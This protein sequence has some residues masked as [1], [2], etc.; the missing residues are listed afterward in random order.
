MCVSHTHTHTHLTNWVLRWTTKSGNQRKTK[1]SP[2]ARGVVVDGVHIPSRQNTHPDVP[3]F[4]LFMREKAPKRQ[5]ARTARQEQ[6]SG[7]NHNSLKFNLSKVDSGIKRSSRA[8]QSL[9]YAHTHTHSGSEAYTH[10]HRFLSR[11]PLFK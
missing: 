1:R 3:P 5:T 7:D 10:R 8:Q 6:G 2:S 9:Y 11:P 4:P